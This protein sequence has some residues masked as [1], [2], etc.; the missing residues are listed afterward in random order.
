MRWTSTP[1]RFEQPGRIFG[2]ARIQ[3]QVSLALGSLPH[4][5]AKPRQ[6]DIAVANISQRAVCE[7]APF[8]APVLKPGGFLV[9]SGFLQTQASEVEDSL[10]A[11]GLQ[12]V[13]R[14]PREDWV[15]LVFRGA[16]G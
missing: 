9:A 5:L 13:D 1:R 7:R 6:F 11:L 2:R 16:S 8:L 15:T 12:V 4:P 3:R 14:G 10:G